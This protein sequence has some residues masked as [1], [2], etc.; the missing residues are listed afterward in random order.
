MTKRFGGYGVVWFG[1]ERVMGL[2][3]GRNRAERASDRLGG[4]RDS[5][6]LQEGK[7]RPADPGCALSGKR[8]RA[9]GVRADVPVQQISGPAQ[10]ASFVVMDVYGVMVS[11]SLATYASR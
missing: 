6:R 2:G 1:C 11:I 8:K 9:D 3:R 10:P 5:A 7:Q 4:S